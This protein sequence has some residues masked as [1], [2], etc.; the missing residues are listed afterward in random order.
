M[1]RRDFIIRVSGYDHKTDDQIEEWGRQ[2]L[3]CFAIPCV[4]EIGVHTPLAWAAD[5]RPEYNALSSIVS[6]V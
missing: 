3:W 5:L 6:M 2:D 4:L 1:T